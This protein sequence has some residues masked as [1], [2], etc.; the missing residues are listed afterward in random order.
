MVGMSAAVIAHGRANVVENRVDLGDERFDRLV[1]QVGSLERFVQVRDVGIV[2]LAVM[3]F[4]GPRVDVR[5]Q[6]VERIWE[7]GEC[8]SH[9]GN[10]LRLKDG[11]C[12]SKNPHASQHTRSITERQSADKGAKSA[13]IRLRPRLR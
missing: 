8:V 2:V 6:G 11:A 1:A 3:N 9:G 4:H 13:I 10:L 5:L 7:R 12:R